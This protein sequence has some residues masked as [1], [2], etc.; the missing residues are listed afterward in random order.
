MSREEIARFGIE[1]RDLHETQWILRTD[2]ARQYSAKFSLHKSV[3]QPEFTGSRQYRN[4]RIV[5]GCSD[6][7]GIPLTYRRELSKGEGKGEAAIYLGNGEVQLSP[8]T[9]HTPE[10][11][12]EM[13]LINVSADEI[14]KAAAKPVIEI[15]EKLWLQG[16]FKPRVTKLSTTGLS[17]AFEELLRRCAE[18]KSPLTSAPAQAT[19]R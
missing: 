10:K 19:A 2:K 15:S 17:S 7:W 9:R 3:T 6:H 18:N 4:T 12:I 8:R 16:E 5:I 13:R 14:R 1:T 11:D